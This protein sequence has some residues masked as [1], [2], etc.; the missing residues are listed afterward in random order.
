VAA[1]NSAKLGKPTSASRLSPRLWITQVNEVD[2]FY[3]FGGQTGAQSI[4]GEALLPGKRH[5]PDI[6]EQVHARFAQRQHKAIDVS[7]FVPDRVNT[8]HRFSPACLHD[9]AGS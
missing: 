6:G 3:A 4:L 8:C 1:V 7:A 5:G 2:I 9:V